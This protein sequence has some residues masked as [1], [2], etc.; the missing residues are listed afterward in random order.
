MSAWAPIVVT[1]TA[2]T[3]LDALDDIAP[4]G[5]CLRSAVETQQFV[6][7]MKASRAWIKG[8]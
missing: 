4:D 7:G 8:T 6:E 5:D 2:E 1:Q 3:D